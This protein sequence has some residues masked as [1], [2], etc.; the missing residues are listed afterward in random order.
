MFTQFFNSNL[1]SSF[2]LSQALFFIGHNSS[3]HIRGIPWKGRNRALPTGG[4]TNGSQCSDEGTDGMLL[5]LRLYMPYVSAGVSINSTKRET[6]EKG[7]RTTLQ[8]TQKEKPGSIG[9]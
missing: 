4:Q 2:E 1:H 6:G 8:K 5:L 3:S 9:S 7:G